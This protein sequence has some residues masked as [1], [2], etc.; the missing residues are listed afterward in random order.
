VISDIRHSDVTTLT[1]HDALTRTY[2]RSTVRLNANVVPATHGETTQ[3][4]LGS[5]DAT[6]A[7]QQ[8]TL[9]QK[10]LTYAF[11][12][13]GTAPE[14]SLEVWV[15]DVKWEEVPTLFGRGPDE[16]VY[17]ARRQDDGTTLIEFGDG[18]RAARLP[19]GQENVRAVYRK[20]VGLEGLVKNPGQLKLLLTQ[21]LGVKAVSNP[22]AATGAEDPL[23]LADA[24]RQVPRCALTLDRVVS[25]RDYEDFARG[26]PGVAKA[27]AVWTWSGDTRGVF[28]TLLGPDG[29]PIAEAGPPA[30]P[31][32]E[33]FAAQSNPLVPVRIVSGDISLLRLAGTV[34][35]AAD[36]LPSQVETAL[37]ETLLAALSFDVREFGQA[38][39]RSELI[40]LI[41]NVAGVVSVDLD[42]MGKVTADDETVVPLSPDED[43][44]AARKPSSG[45]TA[46]RA[47]PAELLI[48]DESSLTELKVIPV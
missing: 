44:L 26:F 46:D 42:S 29:S 11:A 37:R 43:F 39:Y 36:R 20:G 6:Q 31:L 21:P 33:A 22:L 7:H 18:R 25:L 40:A 24:R 38:V 47:Q 19:T 17:I 45:V 13:G 15:D 41:Q 34:R 35:V 10:P 27:L 1:L 2:Q 28:L 5:G 4:V 14:S 16:R 3:E 12:R 30:G 32:R 48:L 23:S 8:F 9:K